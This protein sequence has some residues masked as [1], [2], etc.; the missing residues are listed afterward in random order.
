MIEWELLHTRN[1]IQ[2]STW[3]THSVIFSCTHTLSLYLLNRTKTKPNPL[4][5]FVRH[6]HCHFFLGAASF[7]AL[8]CVHPCLVRWE[9]LV[10]SQ[11]HHQSLNRTAHLRPRHL[12]LLRTLS[13]FL[14]LPPLLTI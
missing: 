2:R 13:T 1:T 7:S 8:R 4:F 14:C 6:S 9:F 12:R 3:L 11:P 10:F 5:F